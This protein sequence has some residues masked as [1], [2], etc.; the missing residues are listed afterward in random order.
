MQLLPRPYT[1]TIRRA[2]QRPCVILVGLPL[3]LAIAALGTLMVGGIGLAGLQ[4]WQTYQANRAEL[5]RRA[6][7][8]LKQV[9]GLEAQLEE[10]K[11]RSGMSDEPPDYPE[12]GQGGPVLR[13]LNAA[14][15]LS[16]AETH[17]SRL[18]EDLSDRVQPALENV[19]EQEKAIPQ[20]LPLKVSTQVTS[21]FGKRQNP[22]GIGKEFHNGLDFA[23]DPGDPVISTAWG[24]VTHAGW[25]GGYGK[26]VEVDHGNGY[27]TLYAHL[28]EISVQWGEEVER[29]D[30]V[31]LVG[32]TGRSTAPHLHYSIFEDNEAID[33]QPFLVRVSG[34]TQA[35]VPNESEAPVTARVAN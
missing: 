20:G 16:N 28:S 15:L 6:E 17:V 30:L 7:E 1:L 32:S 19:L 3:R 9:E 5:D 18:T 33:P 34:L 27:M 12:L 24:V 35:P 21:Y 11:E 13:P 14:E 22:F 25:G 29:G 23:G 10:L 4:V 31:G 2:G 26:Y 8:I